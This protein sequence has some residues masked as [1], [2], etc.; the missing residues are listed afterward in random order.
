MKILQIHNE[1]QFKGGEDIVVEVERKQLLSGGNEVFSLIANNKSIKHLFSERKI[2]YE[3]LNSIIEQHSIEVAHIHNV[4]HIIGNDLYK[5]L[6][7]QNIPIVQTLHNF[8]FLCPAG[9][10]MDNSHHICEKC[11]QGSFINCALK[12]CYQNSH[13]KSFGMSVL[14][15]NGREN[16]L[17]YV[18]KF[19]VLNEFSRNK[20]VQ[21]GFNPDKLVVKSNFIDDIKLA[22]SEY[23]FIL[24][25]GR[26]SP[27]KGVESLIEAFVRLELP[28][29]IAGSGDEVYVGKLKALAEKNKQIEFLGYVQGESKDELIKKSQLLIIPSLCYENFPVSILEAYSY[30]KPIIASNIGGI[31]FIV[32]DGETGYLFEPGNIE[33]LKEAVI[34]ILENDK[35]IELGINGF[36]YFSENFTEKQ[37]Y[38]QLMEIYQ[39]AIEAKKLKN[40]T[41]KSH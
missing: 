33:S 39:S 28:I 4:Y 41:S 40:D 36:K 6:S 7:F 13:L 2:Y 11:S 15:K 12:K 9:L 32:K 10:F 17:K 29:K 38:P 37:N 1:Y 34:K 14:A 22:T 25:I 23:N 16:V 27:E 20:F 8:R 5:L 31:P 21:Y 30:G 19:I 18:D 26:L 24:Y 3:Q 35:F